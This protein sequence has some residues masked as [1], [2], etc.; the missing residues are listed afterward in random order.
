[1]NLSILKRSVILGASLVI[2]FAASCT[3]SVRTGPLVEES[4]SVDLGDAETVQAEIEMGAGKLSIAGGSRD[5]MDAEFTYN[6]AEW[7]PVIEYSV[8]G[9]CGDLEVRMPSGQGV[10][11]GRGVKCEWDLS[12]NDDVSMDLYVELGA[13][14]SYLR[15][16]SLHLESLKLKTGAGAV[17]VGV[18]GSRALRNMEIETGAGAVNVDLAGEWGHDLA[19][20]ISGGIGLVTLRLPV[21][22][23]VRVDVSKG[24][25]MVNADDFIKRDGAYLNEAYG[26]SD[27]TISIEVETGIGAINLELAK[28]P[29]PEGTII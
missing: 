28:P 7:K 17:F 18:G 8:T 5:L 22:V 21:D 16:E 20:E 26:K 23:G 2:V 10:R 27:V 19:A 29:G 25:G 9:T 11:L 24:I 1:V 4:R 6:V 3:E 15:L 13:G 14:E 12:F